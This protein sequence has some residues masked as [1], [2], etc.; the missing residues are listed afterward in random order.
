VTRSCC[1]DSKGERQARDKDHR[2]PG[3]SWRRL[4][5]LSTRYVEEGAPAGA[6]SFLHPPSLHRDGKAVFGMIVGM[7]ALPWNL[8]GVLRRLGVK[9]LSVGLNRVQG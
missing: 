8:D 1:G 2:L 7:I 4:T 5:T 3:D 6:P 9:G